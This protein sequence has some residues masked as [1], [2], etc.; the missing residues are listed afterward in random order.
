MWD[1]FFDQINVFIEA[2]AGD[3]WVL[4][5]VAFLCFIDGIIPL[6]PSDTVVVALAAVG[7]S[8]VGQPHLVGLFLVASVG[9]FLGDQ[10]A[11]TI[12]RHSP[13]AR[14]VESRNER[15]RRM[16]GWADRQLERRGAMIIIAGRYIP[17]GRVAVN[18]TAGAIKYPRLRFIQFDAIASITWG[19]YC[20]LI[21][22]VAGHWLQDNPLLSA[23]IAVCLA[24]AIGYAIDL[25]MQRRT[26]SPAV[27]PVSGAP[28]TE[29]AA[30]SGA[31]G[32]EVGGSDGDGT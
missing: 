8:D 9:A 11:Y 16:M 2:N 14:L 31:A 12:G 7:A 1:T 28:D 19:A 15:M 6:F 3:W 26:G 32:P 4:P 24:V 18:F 23:A 27:G 22:A 29:P 30:G 10:T 21:G 17:V 5:L 20:V 13:L 25:F